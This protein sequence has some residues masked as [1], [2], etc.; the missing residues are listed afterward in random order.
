MYYCIFE[1]QISSRFPIK[2]LESGDNNKARWTF[3]EESSRTKSPKLQEH[4][5][6]S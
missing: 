3:S 2:M 5:L 4:R 1:E 6:C